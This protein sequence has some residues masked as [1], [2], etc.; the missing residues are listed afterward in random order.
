[1]NEY[2]IQKETLTGLADE[3]RVLSGATTPIS[4]EEMT[5]SVADAN[6]EVGAQTD[7]I[8][9]IAEAL[10]G[11]AV[12]TGS[13]PYSKAQIIEWTPQSDTTSM[14]IAHSLGVVP[15]GFYVI[16]KTDVTNLQNGV[17]TLNMDVNM[18]YADVYYFVTGV[19]SSQ[20]G[21]ETI[22]YVITDFENDITAQ[23]ISANLDKT[24]KSGVTYE[25]LVYK[26]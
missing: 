5:S 8:A 15:D 18:L 6:T 21:F 10:E 9:Q 2:L 1:M 20:S 26:R 12:G 13:G 11:K 3:I 24:F 7:L 22:L 16:S 17:I 14:S 19:A 25:I 4:T 23:R